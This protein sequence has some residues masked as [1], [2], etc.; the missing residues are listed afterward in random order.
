MNGCS[1]NQQPRKGTAHEALLR[2]RR[3]LH[4]A[5]HRSSR[6]RT[7]LRSRA[8]RHPQ[9]E[10]RRR[11]RLLEDQPQ[12]LRSGSHAG[13]R[14]SPDRGRGHLPV[15]RRPETP[16]RACSPIWNHGALPPDGS[17]E[18]RIVRSTQADRRAFQP[19]P[20]GGNEGGPAGRDRASSRCSREA[21]RRQP[22]HY[23]RQIHGG[24]RLSVHGAQLD[25]YPQDRSRKM[26][27]HQGIHGSNRCK[28]EGAGNHAGGRSAGIAHTHP[29]RL[30]EV[31]SGHRPD[32]RQGARPHGAAH[33]A[34]PRRRGDRIE[35]PERGGIEMKLLRRN[36]LHLAAGAAALSAASRFAGA[37]A[38]PARPVRIIV[39]F[40]AGGP[41]DIVARVMAQ[42]LS[43]RLGHQFVV[44]NRAGA[45][46]NIGTEAALRAPPDGYTLLQVTSS[47]AVNA[48]FY[49]NLSFDFIND[50]APVG[51]IIPVPFVMEVNPSVPARTV[52]EF[53]AYAKAN[54]GRINMASGGTGTSIHIAGELFKMMAGVN[55]V[56]VPYRGSAPA[57]TDMIGGQVHVM[58][59]VLTSS[60]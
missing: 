55:L 2:P 25:Q 40:P 59:D 57:L 19:E 16:S 37:Q 4:G 1:P 27:E 5:A 36:F 17:A 42:W 38:Y 54:P 45:A 20:D 33:V 11:R 34:R 13:R 46:S 58:F 30:H 9:Q 60:I 26:A 39:G 8:G 3:L 47:N 49:E 10:D 53:I 41:T 31:R 52:P 56:H 23:R 48:T 51:A 12:G 29:A 43:Q 18:L 21:A 6:S 44:E 7:H 22:I 15:P 32:D 24:R 50:I 14:T 35:R 28:A